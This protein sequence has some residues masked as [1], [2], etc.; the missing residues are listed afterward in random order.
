MQV[1]ATERELL[2]TWSKSQVLP[3]RQVMRAKICLL[4]AAGTPNL[5][6]ARRLGCSLPTVGKWRQRFQEAG[7]DGLG[8]QP[9]R[10][11]LATYGPKL[12]DRVVSLTLSRPPR[13]E[14][15]W[16]T[17]SLAARLGISHVTVHRIWRDHRIQPHRSSTFKFSSDPQLVEK[18]T[19]VVG[20]Y[21]DPPEKAVVLSVDEKSQ[22]QALD[23]TQP[24]LPMRPGQVER[25][26]HD[27]VRHGTT[28]LFAA[29]DVAS[30]EVT[31]RC[32][33]RHRHQDFLRFLRLVARTY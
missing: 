20:L 29:L 21:L 22:I 7:M 27:Y 6:I 14:T 28:T 12:E 17:R 15:H 4:A 5:E 23:R 11:R 13:G 8:D 25:R 3:Q 16:S 31:G 24:L 10:G 33:A 19:D 2:T 18:V 30:G 1:D 32:Y 26:T 9:G